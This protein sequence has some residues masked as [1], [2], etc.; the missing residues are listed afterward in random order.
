MTWL[1]VLSSLLVAPSVIAV[2]AKVVLLDGTRIDGEAS[3]DTKLGVVVTN[4]DNLSTNFGFSHIQSI[5]FNVSTNI[6]ETTSDLVFPRGWTNMDIGSVTR[7]GTARWENEQV[8]CLRSKW[9]SRARTHPWQ[10]DSRSLVHC[11]GGTARIPEYDLSTLHLCGDLYI[12]T[13]RE[14]ATWMAVQDIPVAR[15]IHV[16]PASQAVGAAVVAFYSTLK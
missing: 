1:S 14:K 11:Y 6:S 2:S 15:M 7:A 10:V 8:T 16:D 3:I 13:C 12:I 9:N 4:S 5:R